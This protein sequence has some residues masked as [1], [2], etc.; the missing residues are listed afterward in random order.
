[1]SKNDDQYLDWL[2]AENK[3]E[4]EQEQDPELSLLS[5]RELSHPSLYI[6]RESSFLSFNERVL[7]MASDPAIPVIERLKYLCISSSNLDEFFEV[8]VAGLKRL[9]LDEPNKTSLDGLNAEA[10]LELVSEKAHALVAQQYKILNDKVFPTLRDHDIRFLRRDEWTPEIQSW[11]AEYFKAKVYPVLTP[12]SLDPAH[13]FP[14]LLNKSMSFLIR[15]SGEDSFGRNTGLALLR[16]PRVLPRVIKLPQHLLSNGYNFVFLS[17]IIHAQI[18]ALFPGMEPLGVYQFKLT[19][20]SDLSV[21]D[22]EVADLR[23]ALESELATRQYGATVRLEVVNSMPEN[24]VQMLLRQFSLEESDLYRVNG[25]VNL[26][27]LMAVIG[28]VNEPRLAFPAFSPKPMA[29]MD[30]GLTIFDRLSERDILIHQPYQSMEPVVEFLRQAARDPAVVAVKQTLYRTGKDSAFVDA[31]VDAVER[32]KDVTVVVELRARFDEADN[33]HL[34][35]RLQRAGIQVVY[36]VVGYKTHAKMSMVIRRENDA[37]VRYVHVGTGNYHA[38]TARSYTD[39]GLLTRNKKITEDVHQVFKQLTGLGH[40]AKMQA[41]YQSPFTMRSSIEENIDRE[42]VNVREGRAGL[43]MA[44]MNS[45]V[46]GGLIKALY[47]ASQAGVKIDLIVRGACCL[48]PGVLGISENIRVFSVLGR[49]LEHSRIFYFFNAGEENTFISSADWMP[50]NLYYR[51]ELAA[52]ILDEEL[53]QKVIEEG[54]L[55]QIDDT[56]GNWSLQS[57]GHYQKVQ[58]SDDDKPKNSQQW[59]INRYRNKG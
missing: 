57:D 43:I 48:R 6:N 18:G 58:P 3:I 51:V 9:Q 14:R 44:R 25:P 34:A 53:R 11:A 4:Q 10:Q 31:L 46:D 12:V 8:R 33:I 16:T 26:T 37:L 30:R 7:S 1:M 49:F 40:A 22:E 13:P 19:R 54:L 52:P 23:R 55:A 20:N 32:G 2:K 59:L 27:R 15:L 39:F 21:E 24:M 28:M 56:V 50:R 47:R 29:R 41:C 36:G 38:G 17:S 42:I 5:S 35:R 45:L